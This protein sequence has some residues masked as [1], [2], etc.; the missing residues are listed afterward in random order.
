MAHNRTKQA[1]PRKRKLPAYKHFHLSKRVKHPAQL[2]SAFS[3]LVRAVRHLW[4]HKKLYFWILAI[5]GLLTLVLV[6][7][8]TGSI[9][10]NEIKDNL[11][12]TDGSQSGR[13]GNSLTLFGF[14]LG[15]TGGTGSEAGSAYQTIL[16][17]IASLAVIW[18]LRQTHAS[19]TA[20]GLKA[21]HAYY[22]GMYPLVPFTLVLVVVALQLIP[23]AI[24]GSL[25]TAV[26]GG[27]LAVSGLEQFLWAALFALFSILSLYMITSSVFA[28]YISTLPDMTPMK[29]LRS[30][31]ELVRY[32][33]WTVLRK[34]VLLPIFL[35]IVAAV[36]II[37]AIILLTAVGEP[38]FF[39]FSLVALAIIHAYM[40]ELYRELIR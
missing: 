15:S 17:I 22:G 35:L 19:K 34:I 33:R 12:Q 37:P 10:L 26:I 11:E 28:L 1:G 27:G 5:Y 14:L 3:L 40:Y 32:R 6:K 8:L 36:L 23:L 24:G 38:L 30:A 13:L 21:R 29:A 18:G 16:L 20:K 25:Y 4:L 39:V 7:G 2:P 31:R 9:N